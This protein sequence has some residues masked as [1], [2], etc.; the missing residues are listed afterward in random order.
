MELQ[1]LGLVVDVFVAVVVVHID[2]EQRHEVVFEHLDDL[3]LKEV[4]QFSGGSSRVV[5]EAFIHKLQ[6]G[7]LL[8]QRLLKYLR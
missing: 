4:V 8:A 6:V 2:T 3:L 5:S 1:L 7:L